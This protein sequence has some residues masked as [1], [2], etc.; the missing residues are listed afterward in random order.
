MN[1]ITG[2]FQ[3]KFASQKI[4]KEEII[5]IASGLKKSSIKKELLYKNFIKNRTPKNEQDNKTYRNK[6]NHLVRIAKKNYYSQ[7]FSR[8]QNDIKSTWNT[9]NELLDKNKTTKPLLGT[10]MN[11]K[12]EEIS[13]PKLIANNFNEFSVLMQH[14]RISYISQTYS[15]SIFLYNN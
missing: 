9:I 13:D 6:L 1:Y 12:N 8:A 2:L 11:N 5:W 14:Q 7:K 4:P 3:S 15:D 10:F